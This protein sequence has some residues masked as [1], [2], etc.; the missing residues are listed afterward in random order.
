M[1]PSVNL[2]RNAVLV[3]LNAYQSISKVNGKLQ[4]GEHRHSE[5]IYSDTK[6]RELSYQSHYNHQYF[7]CSLSVCILFPLA[8]TIFHFYNCSLQEDQFL[9]AEKKLDDFSGL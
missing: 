1:L 2:L 7:P 9:K 8:L 3:S 6:W 5:F 4:S